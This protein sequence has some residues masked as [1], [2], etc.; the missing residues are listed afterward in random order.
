[1]ETNKLTK[2]CHCIDCKYSEYQAYPYGKWEA[3][4]QGYWCHWWDFE[5]K[6]D[7]FCSHGK[8]KE[9]VKGDG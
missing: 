5:M 8:M 1:M 4:T 6:P 7:D 2:G 3:P 9:D